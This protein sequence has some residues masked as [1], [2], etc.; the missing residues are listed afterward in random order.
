MIYNATDTMK[1]HHHL[2]I[3][4][5]LLS[6]LNLNAQNLNDNFAHEAI[7]DQASKWGAVKG[8]AVIGELDGKKVLMV[9]RYTVVKPVVNGKE[10]NYLG[11][12]FT[13]EF[14]A[15]FDK[16]PSSTR[17][18]YI[19]NLWEGTGVHGENKKHTDP[20]MIFR[21]GINVT[22]SVV[23]KKRI[24]ELE[25]LEQVWR[26]IKIDYAK[27][28]LKIFIDDQLVHQQPN[29]FYKPKMV[30][31]SA[32]N[33]N[34]PNGITNFTLIGETEKN[35][36]RTP[37]ICMTEDLIIPT[38]FQVNA[39]VS[40][41]DL[42]WENGKTLKVSFLDKPSNI[43]KTNIINYA[44]AWETYANIKFEFIDGSDGDIRIGLKKGGSWSKVG[45]DALNYPE[46]EQ[47][48]NFGW[49]TDTTSTASFRRTTIHEFGHAIGLKHEHQN[50]TGGI[51][52]DW[53]AVYDYYEEENDWSEQRTKANLEM[54]SNNSVG[55]ATAYDSKSIMHYP[56]PDSITS[57]EYSVAWNSQLSEMD[58]NLISNFYPFRKPR[59]TI[60]PN[61]YNY[62]WT[63]EWDSVEFL[64]QG[65]QTYLLLLKSS[66]GDVHIHKMRGDGSVG[67]RIFDKKYSSGWTSAKFFEVNNRNYLFLLK[68]STGD[69]HIHQINTDGTV[70]QRIFDK[71]WTSGW[72]ET[73]FYTVGNKTYLFLYKYQT[74]DVHVNR[75][76]SNGTVGDLIFNKKW[77]PEWT[78]ASHFKTNNKS[79]MFLI[80]KRT[81]DVHINEI[82]TDGTI[83]QKV[84]D[85]KWTQG[86]TTAEFYR[87]NAQTYLFLLKLE[88]GDA[89]QFF[90][91]DNGQRGEIIFDNNAKW[92]SGWS[93]AKFYSVG[94][95]NYMFLLKEENG[96]AHTN[97]IY[98]N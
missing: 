78:T 30:S 40:S 58:K 73:Q 16:V 83:G 35:L 62:N 59:H 66:T 13:I 85:E 22:G 55:N 28:T 29:L 47:T 91:T 57:C 17:Q 20:Y 34:G 90:I 25:V 50:P 7:N 5:V 53:E 14:D 4:L 19:I 44:K 54:L 52:W 37:E 43:V 12:Q 79:Y 71:K 67:E 74:G 72:S 46:D 96:T 51:C 38:T 82:N 60:G 21:H 8:S 87:T 86:W 98:S 69:V 32:R 76:N 92:T 11:D 97:I 89:K 45:T 42:L 6:M 56:I 93:H 18:Y 84:F 64:N 10:T 65:G 36:T 49:F 77:T 15:F 48:M 31:L 41:K 61:I 1:K 26:H 9:D 75:I 68:Q 33:A 88:N 27:N 24:K 3:L 80:K 94:Q 2:G 81:G 39:L 63:A 70:G 23:N 95:D